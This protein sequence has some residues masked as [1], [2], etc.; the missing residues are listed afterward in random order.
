MMQ[1]G[2]AS[3]PGA[4]TS[5]S[6]SGDQAFT[7]I[8]NNKFSGKS[9]ELRFASGVLSADVNGDKTADFAIAL[10][11]VSSFNPAWVVL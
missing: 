4:M 3:T 2:R 5:R 7:F 9:G 8:G 6:L 1:L 11:K 10:S